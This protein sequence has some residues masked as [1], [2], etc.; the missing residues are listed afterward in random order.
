MISGQWSVVSGQWSMVSGKWS[1]NGQWSAVTAGTVSGLRGQAVGGRR[2]AVIVWRS[3]STVGPV[4]R[5]PPG[6]DTAEPLIA[7]TH[8]P[9]ST[10]Y[11]VRHNGLHGNGRQRRLLYAAAP[12]NNPG[13]TCPA[14]VGGGGGGRRRFS[15]S[16]GLGS[17]RQSGARSRDSFGPVLGG[18]ARQVMTANDDNVHQHS[19]TGWFDTV[20]PPQ[21]M[22]G[23]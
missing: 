8:A 22:L 2:S 12:V 6:S 17:V 4:Q 16:R 13:Q 11:G 1:V 19:M 21:S 20:P 10:Q 14:P 15:E 23:R 9:G 5:S 3:A 18:L 7:A